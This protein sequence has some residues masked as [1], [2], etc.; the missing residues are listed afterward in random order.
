MLRVCVIH[1]ESE[2]VDLAYGEQRLA[3][4]AVSRIVRSD[5]NDGLVSRSF[6]WVRPVSLPAIFHHSCSPDS[7][8]PGDV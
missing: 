8:L 6:A 2:R 1:P 7:R 5:R 4:A 3:W